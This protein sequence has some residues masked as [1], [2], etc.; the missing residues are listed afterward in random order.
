M[1]NLIPHSAYPCSV[2][3]EQPPN[4]YNSHIDEML[5]EYLEGKK[6]I[7]QIIDEE[8]IRYTREM[9]DIYRL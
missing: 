6:S 4:F 8:M 2:K 5:I 3:E 9:F 1:T 7:E